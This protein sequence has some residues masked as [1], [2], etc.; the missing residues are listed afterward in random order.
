MKPLYLCVDDEGC[1]CT[2]SGV[3]HFFRGLVYIRKSIDDFVSI[4]Q[5]NNTKPH[6]GSGFVGDHQVVELK[7]K[8]D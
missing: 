6:M 4:Y 2:S 7:R 8:L 1:S 3:T 5:D